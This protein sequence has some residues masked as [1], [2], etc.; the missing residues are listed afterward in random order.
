MTTQGKVVHFSTKTYCN[1]WSEYA[2]KKYA[3]VKKL[4]YWKLQRLTINGILKKIYI[5]FIS[6]FLNEIHFMDNQN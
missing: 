6:Y 5:M 2:L 1:C 4:S 3:A